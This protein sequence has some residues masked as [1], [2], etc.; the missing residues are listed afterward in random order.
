MSVSNVSH[1]APTA[2]SEGTASSRKLPPILSG[3]LP[4]IGHALE[5]RKRPVTL[6]QRGR[7]LYGEIFGIRLPGSP[8]SVVMSGPKAH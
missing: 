7:D 8:M 1:D 2:K 5:M 4:L 6:F 3:G